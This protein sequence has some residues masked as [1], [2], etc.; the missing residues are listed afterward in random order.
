M[1]K[2]PSRNQF[3]NITVSDTNYFALKALGQAGDS[4]N[5]VITKLLRERA[6]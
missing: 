3:K 4:Y 5:D 2:T 6:N 1:D